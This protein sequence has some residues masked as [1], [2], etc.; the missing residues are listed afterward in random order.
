MVSGAGGE[1][2]KALRAL[3]TGLVS[4]IWSDGCRRVA[5]RR[6]LDGNDHREAITSLAAGLDAPPDLLGLACELVA[7]KLSL[8]VTAEHGHLPHSIAVDTQFL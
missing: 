6:G 2:A 8:D 1:A 7:A 5:N 3:V 4:V